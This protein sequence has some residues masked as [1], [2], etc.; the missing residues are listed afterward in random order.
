MEQ[1]TRIPLKTDD[2]RYE[3]NDF[4]QTECGIMRELTVTITLA[5]YRALVK[6]LG[7]W[8][9][10]ALNADREAAALKNTLS[11]AAKCLN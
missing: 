7:Y 9:S 2:P 5:E 11:E 6:D 1:T 10:K 3:R 8:Q 4:E